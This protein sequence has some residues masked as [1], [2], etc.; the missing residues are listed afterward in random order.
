M[1]E[2]L[3]NYDKYAIINN[4][5]KDGGL[6]ESIMKD[7]LLPR[8]NE[9]VNNLF[10]K[11]GAR[12]VNIKYESI[13]KKHVINIYDEHERNTNRDGGYQTFLNNLIYRIALSELNPNMRSQFMIIDEAL[14][15]ADSTNKQ[16]MKKL[17]N[18]LRTQYEWIMIVSH[19]D[20]VKDSF[21]NMIEICDNT[22]DTTNSGIKQ[23]T[24][25]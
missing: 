8:F 12:P 22:N 7:N 9:I 18:Y 3:E 1:K 6:I 10:V 16:E 13:G 14:D 4:I 19:N 11:F 25:I 20:D 15:S 2:C 21:D 23:I 24:Y 5:L 17:I